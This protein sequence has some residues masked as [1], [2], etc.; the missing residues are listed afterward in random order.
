M[1]TVYKTSFLYKYIFIAFFISKAA[2]MA[3]NRSMCDGGV[4]HQGFESGSIPYGWVV[5][6][7][8][9]DGQT[10]ETTM[11]YTHSG[12]FSVQ[13]N[14][15]NGDDWLI[16][17]R[18]VVAIGDSFTFWA[19]SHYH[20]FL[21]DFEVLVST[22][23]NT[24]DSFTV[25]LDLVS[26]T[27]SDWTYYSYSLDTFIG[28]EIFLAIRCMVVGTAYPW[29]YVDD[30]AGPN[31]WT[32][33][34]P[35]AYFS[36]DSIQYVGRLPGQTGYENL[37]LI[38]YGGVDLNITG[39]VID[40]PVFET[41]V[42]SLII[43]PCSSSVIPIAFTPDT[44]ENYTGNIIITSNALT[45][46]DTV[47][48]SG[49]GTG[50]FFPHHIGDMWE[51]LVCN[52]LMDCDTVQVRIILDSL[53][54]DGNHY[55]IKEAHKINPFEYPF[56]FW[57]TTYYFI[58]TLNQVYE[59]RYNFP[60]D[61]DRLI[62]KPGVNVGDWWIVDGGIG[63]EIAKIEDVVDGNL[64]GEI[65][66]F[67]TIGFYFGEDTSNLDLYIPYIAVTLSDR[68]GLIWSGGG[69]AAGE[70]YIIGAVI[71]GTLYG[72][73][74]Q[75]SVDNYHNAITTEKP[76][77]I[78]NYPN[79]FNKATVI[80]FDLRNPTSITLV[81]YDISGKEVVQLYDNHPMG[82]GIYEIS[83]DGNNYFGNPVASGV[84]F[85]QLRYDNNIITN[86]MILLR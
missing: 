77:L 46:P 24:L 57:D 50:S 51:Y 64:F 6:D 80:R 18:L 63:N 20:N 84:Y 58:D 41:E 16:T 11:N 8:N 66:T 83:W 26:D 71:D 42:F 2:L 70:L 1:V 76:S 52:D 74:T 49:R 61:N 69:E 29:M 73:I 62:F 85:Y 44:N 32:P 54:Q 22:T 3:N 30:I 7:I 4:L 31:I 40:N 68:F 23:E 67:K 47:R 43:Q 14:S 36:R 72:D 37:T 81:I 82:S 59:Q 21:D 35:V 33:P 28:S 10:W 34:Y 60:S 65:T 13:V 45:S 25:V 9:G 17:P 56:L 55:L 15:A 39:V 75:L 27:P 19:K 48:L 38:N 79:P 86:H 12:N 5:H 78:Q 53:D